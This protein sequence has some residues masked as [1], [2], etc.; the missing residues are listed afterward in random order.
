MHYLYD[1]PDDAKRTFLFA[2]GAGAPMTHPFMTA[3]AKGMGERGVR[4]VRFNFPYMEAKKKMPDRQPVLLDAWRRAIE[5]HGGGAGVVIGGKSMG[6]RMASMVADEM[7]VRGLVCFG[8]PFHPPGRTEK[9]RVAHLEELHTPS[10]IIQGTRDTFGT[11]ED[12]SSYRLSSSI[13]VRWIEN[14]DHSL[15]GGLEQAIE[16]AVLFTFGH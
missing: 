11:R 13:E 4:V 5:E 8:Y 9:L 6:G 2:H 15:K 12:V 16:C 7:Q 1:G 10:L 14:A 3:V